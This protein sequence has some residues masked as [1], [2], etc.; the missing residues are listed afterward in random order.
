MDPK[1]KAVPVRVSVPLA[2][3]DPGRYECQV[4]VLDPETQKAAFWRMPLAIVP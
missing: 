1:S 2:G 4:T 3:I